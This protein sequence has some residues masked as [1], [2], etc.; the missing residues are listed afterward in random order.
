MNG[1][2]NK[3]VSGKSIDTTEKE[4]REIIEKYIPKNK[5]TSLHLE[6]GK[7]VSNTR[8]HA[9][10]VL[11]CDKFRSYAESIDHIIDV[12]G[13]YNKL[14]V[15]NH[16]YCSYTIYDA[17][18][19]TVRIEHCMRHSYSFAKHIL[20][21]GNRYDYKYKFPD[22]FIISDNVQTFQDMSCNIDLPD[23][24]LGVIDAWGYVRKGI[25]YFTINIYDT[26]NRYTRAR[27][28]VA[29]PDI[30]SATINFIDKW[31]KTE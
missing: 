17:M 16:S 27:P 10:L 1:T 23:D 19:Y 5:C 24:F 29:I 25:H 18:Q 15:K 6:I 12:R 11:Y 28:I 9:C 4:K 13:R 3:L 26:D 21:N 14:Y 8:S 2:L 31:T 30:K 22:G 20:I 7:Y